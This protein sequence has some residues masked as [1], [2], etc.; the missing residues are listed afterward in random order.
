M[1]LSK[2]SLREESLWRWGLLPY[3]FSKQ[4]KKAGNS[5][6]LNGN[7]RC[8]AVKEKSRRELSKV[9]HVLVSLC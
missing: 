6:S 4:K 9:P 2:T 8:L 7:R 5:V 3:I 1:K